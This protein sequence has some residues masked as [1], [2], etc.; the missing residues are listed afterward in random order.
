MELRALLGK[1]RVTQNDTV[2]EQHSRDES[3]HKPV[4]PDVVVFPKT[5]EEVSEI[6]KLATKYRIPVVPFGMGSSLGG[7][8]DS[9]SWRDFSGFHVDE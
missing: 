9:D 5:T 3:Y 7:K 2:L 8:C 4:L 6:M 1:E